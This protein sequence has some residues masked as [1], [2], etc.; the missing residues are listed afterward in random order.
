M[1]TTDDTTTTIS[2][3]KKKVVIALPGDTYSSSFLVNWSNTLLS[4]WASDKYEFAIAPAGGPFLPHVRMLTLGLEVKNGIDQKPFKGD[5]FDIWLTIDSYIIFTSD[6]I[7]EILASAEKHPAVGGMYR[8]ADLLHYT[9]IKTWDNE[10]FAKNGTYEYIST[11]F[12][13]TWKKETDLRYMPVQYTGLGFFACRK[14]VIDKMVYPY[15]NGE[16]K[17]IKGEN[18]IILKEMSTEDVNFCNNIAKAGFEIVLDTNIRVGNLKP[19]VI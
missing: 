4:L 10:H 16:M 9:A 3:P 5:S 1:Q 2:V 19:I 15:F 13:D 17:E 7:F 12:V 18:G 6:N 11:D 14:E 8:S